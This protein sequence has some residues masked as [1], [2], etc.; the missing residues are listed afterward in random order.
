M[1]THLPSSYNRP[2]QIFGKL[3]KEHTYYGLLSFNYVKN[4][5]LFIT[6]IFRELLVARGAKQCLV[7]FLEHILWL[8]SNA[9]L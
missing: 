9:F 4:C 6:K 3:F 7:L 8:L 1:P 5:S 2:G